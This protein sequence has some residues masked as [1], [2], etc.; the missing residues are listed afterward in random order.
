MQMHDLR[1]IRS[2]REPIQCLGPI[3]HNG[4]ASGE[5]NS[6]KRKL[7][8]ICRQYC[9]NIVLIDEFSEADVSPINPAFSLGDCILNDA[10]LIDIRFVVTPENFCVVG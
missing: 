3:R 7:V 9:V 5:D 1:R 2:G 8:K 10:S 4:D 6:P